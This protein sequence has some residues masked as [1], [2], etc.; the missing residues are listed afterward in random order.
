MG[1]K[2]GGI[3]RPGNKHK[4]PA[5]FDIHRQPKTD[6]GITGPLFTPELQ[7]ATKSVE[8]KVAELG[9]RSITAMRM[10]LCTETSSR[11]TFW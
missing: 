4:K 5:K 11:K 10:V 6:A 7:E 9:V 3:G 1:R 2:Q 8:E